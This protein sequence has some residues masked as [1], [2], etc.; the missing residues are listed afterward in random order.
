MKFKSSFL[1]KK[2]NSINAN[3]YYSGLNYLLLSVSSSISF[4]TV[5][6][7]FSDKV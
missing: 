1:C 6:L 5:F 7:S 2:T 4:N 3:Y